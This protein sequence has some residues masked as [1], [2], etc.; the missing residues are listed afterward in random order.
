MT[1]QRGPMALTLVVVGALIM[2]YGVVGLLDSTSWSAARSIA[3][4]PSF[5][6][7]RAVIV[8]AP[9]PRGQQ[10]GDGG[11]LT[12]SPVPGAR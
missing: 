1:E 12:A 2:A 10:R 11:R 3:L 6:L 9:L 7:I 8:F 4:V 5:M